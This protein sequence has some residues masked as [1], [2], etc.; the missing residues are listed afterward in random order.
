MKRRAVMLGLLAPLIFALA[1]SAQPAAPEKPSPSIESV[2]VTAPKLR[3]EKVLD[4]F[5]MAHTARSTW[6]GKVG[7]WKTGI[8]PVTIGLPDKFDTF[9]T[10]RI[11]KVAMLAGAPLE[12]RDPCRPN[13]IVLATDQPQAL[14][15]VIRAKHS[16]LLG[17][18]YRSQAERIATVRRP[19]QAWY[20]TVTED[21]WGMIKSDTEGLNINSAMSGV[22]ALPYLTG[23]LHVSGMRSFDGLKSE[24]AIV[25]IVID[26]RKIAGQEIGALADYTAMLG[27]SQGTDESYDA[28]QDVPTITNLMAG[29]CDG[30]MKPDGMTDIDLTYLKGLYKMNAGMSYVGER[31][32][33][34]YEMKKELGGY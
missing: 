20:S 19:I 12:K 16:S 24:F 6:L 34:A 14:M 26:T 11:I 22:A 30:A 5:I 32:S 29:A 18:H 31:G 1:A 17:F 7:R 9:V 4:N 15:D 13:L 28:C 27:L 10:Q 21:W 8:C 25:L 2:I 33:I 23:A 3:D